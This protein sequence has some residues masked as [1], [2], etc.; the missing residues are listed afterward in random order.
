VNGRIGKY[1]N[2]GDG[3]VRQSVRLALLV[4]AV[5]AVAAA[6]PARADQPAAGGGCCSPCAPATRTICCTECVPETYQVKRIT[7]KQEQR[8]EKYTAYKCIQV[9]ECRERTVCCNRTV[10]EWVDQ[11]KKVCVKVPCCEERTVCKPCYRTVC[12]TKMVTKCVDRGHWECREEYSHWKAFC[13]GLGDLCSSHSCCSDPCNPCATTCCKPC[14]N[15]CVTRKCWVPCMVQE[16][17]PVTCTRQVCEMRTEVIKVN[18]CRTEWRDQVCKVCVTKCIPETRVE[19]YTV[20]VSKMVP[21]EACRT[22]CVCVPCEETVCCT[23]WVARTVTREVPCC[24]TTT[25]C[26]P[27][28]ESRGHGLFHGC[29]LFGGHG[30]GGCGG[31]FGGCGSGCGGLFGGHS[32]GGSF[33]GCGGCGGLFGGCG[34]LFGGHGCGGCGGGCFGAR[35]GCCN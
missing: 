33:G 22:V 18:T 5:A 16:C 17:C 7:Y 28:C 25:C 10:T 32:C 3:M 6:A 35:T 27:C 23:R 11:C 30:C 21:Y 26:D 9:P 8:T 19:K 1:R 24:P 31:L 20:C 29:S 13:N 4:G 12:E 14:P 34:G 2:K 15:N